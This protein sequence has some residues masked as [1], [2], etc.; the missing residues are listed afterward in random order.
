MYVNR[1]ESFNCTSNGKSKTYTYIYDVI[2]IHLIYSIFSNPLLLESLK[3]YKEHN[4]YPTKVELFYFSINQPDPIFV[5]M[6][7]LNISLY[8]SLL[9]MYTNYY[10]YELDYQI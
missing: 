7:I 9:C 1:L 3:K 10:I 2:K 6:D 5:T 4:N 8:V